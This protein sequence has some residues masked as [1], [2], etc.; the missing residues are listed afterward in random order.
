MELNLKEL[1]DRGRKKFLSRDFDAAERFLSQVLQV[2]NSYADV[3]NMLGVIWHDQGSFGKALDSFREALKINPRYTEASLNLAVV[4]NDLGMYQEARTVYA[5]AKTAQSK[6]PGE[7]DTFV[8]GKLANMHAE[9][10]DIYVGI[11]MYDSSLTEFR[12]A[13]KLRPEFADI[14]TKLA[15]TLHEKGDH[16]SAVRELKRVKKERPEYAPA[17]ISLGL[18]YYTAGKSKEAVDHYEEAVLIYPGFHDLDR[19]IKELRSRIDT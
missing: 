14:R 9:L 18:T 19:H 12:K 2:T 17:R 1:I 16:A 15:K 10:G 8:K 6:T 3:Y 5:Q 11:G 13:L 4:Y 7:P